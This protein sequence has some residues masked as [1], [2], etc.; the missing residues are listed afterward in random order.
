MGSINLYKVDTERA[1]E[2]ARELEAKLHLETTMEKTVEISG[3]ETETF[4]LT[5]YLARPDYRKDI[6]WSWVLDEFNLSNVQIIPAPKAVILVVREDN[7][8]YAVTFGNAFFAVDK[9]FTKLFQCSCTVADR[10]LFF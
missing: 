4:R 9:F 1:A 7:S 5:L 6:S 10:V 2:L 8:T 3:E